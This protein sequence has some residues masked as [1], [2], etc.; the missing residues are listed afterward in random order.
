MA[1]LMKT[2]EKLIRAV[3][4]TGLISIMVSLP[5]F[6]IKD[7]ISKFCYKVPPDEKI[8]GLIFTT[9]LTLLLLAMPSRQSTGIIHGPLTIAMV[10]GRAWVDLWWLEPQLTQHRLRSGWTIWPICALRMSNS[11]IEYLKIF[12][13]G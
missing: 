11:D 10:P 4:A 1:A 7:L 2:T 8:S 13:T 6:L 5:V 12:S 9:T 3:R